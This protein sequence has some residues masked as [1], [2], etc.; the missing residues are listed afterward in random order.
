MIATPFLRFL[1]DAVALDVVHCTGDKQRG[2]LLRTWHADLS[3]ARLPSVER[4]NRRAATLVEKI[5]S[6][7]PASIFFNFAGCRLAR[8]LPTTT[9][10]GVWH[11]VGSEKGLDSGGGHSRDFVQRAHAHPG[12]ILRQ[13]LERILRSSRPD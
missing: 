4:S 6:A 13:R 3:S 2:F 9:S 1:A 5:C 8:A 11:V 12:A 10:A 7:Q